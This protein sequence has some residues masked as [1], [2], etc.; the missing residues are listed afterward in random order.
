MSLSDERASQVAEWLA[1]R[2]SGRFTPA[3]EAALG[4]WLRA[5]PDN[6]AAYDEALVLWADVGLVRSDPQIMRR[7]EAARAALV[8]HRVGLFAAACA[9]FMLGGLG[10][11]RGGVMLLRWMAPP[12]AT[13]AT[14]VGQTMSVGLP[15]GSRA[16]LDTDSE[17]RAWPPG[18]SRQLELVRG[19]AFFAV[20]K[21]PAHPFVV[22][23]GGHRVTALGTRFDVD[24]RPA[25]FR[26]VLSEGH[27]RVSSDRA[28][29][30]PG[31][32]VEMTAGTQLLARAGGWSV[33][34]VDTRTADGW[35][36]GRLVFDDAPLGAIA[37]ELA[38]Y[39]SA[40]I[41]VDPE[42]AGRRMSAVL[43]ASD[44]SAFIASAEAL[45]LARQVDE[46]GA[47]KLGPP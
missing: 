33:T 18:V 30:L 42:V 24:M 2:Q 41:L 31:G 26:V 43:P 29:G 39:S 22:R 1:R 15:D 7:R 16:I 20:A 27:V 3:D 46:P 17:L 14:Q 4:A 23:A 34:R 35:L 13:Y 9:L 47:Y 8:A 37:A 25:S 32:G 12:P 40:P 44:P 11:W 21:D 28:S 6:E 19:R 38:R 36:S 45:G 10:V 5:S